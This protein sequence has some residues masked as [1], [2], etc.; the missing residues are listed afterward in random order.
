MP[1]LPRLGLS[2]A[3]LSFGFYHFFLG[4]ISLPEYQEPTL[5]GIASI[6]YV[7]ALV[8]SVVDFPGLKMRPITAVLVM[9]AAVII[10][11]LVF[12]A[13]GEVRQGSY[14]TWHVAA[15]ATLLSILS[16]RRYPLFAWVG[17]FL[18][19]F[20]I[21]IWGGTAVI[22]N[23]GLV[24]ALLLVT[25]AQLASWALISSAESAERFTARALEIE[26][27]TAASTASRAERQRRVDATLNEVKPILENIVQKKGKLSAKDKAI[28][29]ITEADLR[30]QI[31]GRNLASREVASAIRAARER[32]IEVQLL[33]DGG[34]DD[35]APAERLSYQTEIV[36]RLSGVTSGKVV[37]RAARGEAWRVTI[38]AL[39][40]DEDRPDLFVRI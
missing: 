19:S 5:A 13:L 16:V 20:D 31:R 1:R 17:L 29:V 40:K 10:P 8:A 32:G 25:V 27:A 6:I 14:A 12:D 22:L 3:A 38:V 2:L 28:A 30:D 33:D 18:L 26:A 23:S 9:I 36:N 35:I 24:G 34:L 4:V 39:R 11:H 15:V 7:I 21:V 37:V